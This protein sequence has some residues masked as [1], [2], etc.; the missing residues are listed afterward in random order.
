LNICN[1]ISIGIEN[2][3]TNM[4]SDRNSSG[5]NDLFVDSNGENRGVANLIISMNAIN[6]LLSEISEERNNLNDEGINSENSKFIF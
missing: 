6:N 1:E 2:L 4:N 5:N 3:D